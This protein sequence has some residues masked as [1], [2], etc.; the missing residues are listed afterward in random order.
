MIDED[1]NTIDLQVAM[2]NDEKKEDE[3]DDE[4]DL[5]ITFVSNEI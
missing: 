3:D 1:D 2:A 5:Q 4:V